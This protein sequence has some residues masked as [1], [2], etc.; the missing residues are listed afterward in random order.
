M[1]KLITAMMVVLLLL[2]VSA[3]VTVPSSSLST[4]SMEPTTNLTTTKPVGTSSTTSTASQSTATT[5]VMP[6]PTPASGTYRLVDAYPALSFNQP[7]YFAVA[8]DTSR[9]CFVVERSGKIRV[10]EDR[11]DVQEAQ[12]FLDISKQ[13]DSS[14]QEKGLLGLAFH[15]DYQRNGY[16]YVNYTNQDHTVISRFTRRESNRLEADPASELVLLTIRQP[17]ANHNGGQLAFGSDGFLYIATGDGGSSGDPQNNA[18]NQAS[19]LGKILRIDVDHPANDKPYGIPADNPYAGN[20]T[21]YAEEIFALGLR[22]P[23]RFSFDG[24][25]NL[26]VADVGQNKLEEID[27]VKNG[28]NYGWSA[29]EGSLPY[30]EIPG[31]NLAEMVAPVWEYDREQGK[32]V[33]GGYVYNGDQAPSLKGTYI[34]GDFISGRIWA[35]W[36]FSEQQVKNQLLLKTGLKISSFGIDALG[37]LRIVDYAGKLYRLEEEISGN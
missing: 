16:L 34:Y 13:I 7:L 35:L 24:S 4:D 25:G 14:K 37:E 23:W 17:Y 1:V 27:L 10:F 21:G 31:A 20:A 6:I 8:G 28:G 18:Q 9:D 12:T 3:C 36:D 15:P 32:C 2:A 19:L 26:W 30:K 11:S 22:N 29:R 33:T 5:T